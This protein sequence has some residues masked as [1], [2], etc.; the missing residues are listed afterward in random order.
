MSSYVIL[1]AATN[2]SIKVKVSRFPAKKKMSR[3]LGEVP[4]R[5]PTE[6]AGRPSEVALFEL[7]EGA[8]K[9]AEIGPFGGPRRRGPLSS[10]AALTIWVAVSVASH[11]TSL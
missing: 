9:G 2:H 3:D 1:Y 6:Y 8:L 4:R 7:W 11:G 5:S 10:A